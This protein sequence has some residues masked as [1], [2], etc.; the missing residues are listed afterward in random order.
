MKTENTII[1]PQTNLNNMFMNIEGEDIENLKL[2][3][4]PLNIENAPRK[5]CNESSKIR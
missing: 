5:K 4:P 2:V 1:D 3:S